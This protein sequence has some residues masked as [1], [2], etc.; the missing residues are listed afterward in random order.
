MET[1]DLQISSYDNTI[2]HE[3]GLGSR[4]KRNFRDNTKNILNQ[5]RKSTN[6]TSDNMEKYTRKT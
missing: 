2:D 1:S 5:K 6:G 4:T 3:H